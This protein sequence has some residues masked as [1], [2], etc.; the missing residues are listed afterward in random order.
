MPPYKRAHPTAE[1][2][3]AQ[4]SGFEEKPVIELPGPITAKAAPTCFASKIQGPP[5][6]GPGVKGG[7][8]SDAYKP[9]STAAGPAGPKI[10][11]ATVV[12]T[13]ALDY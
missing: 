8:C 7:H 12:P 6:P 13:Y 3:A 5:M 11:A 4:R 2:L 1:P 10:V 9:L